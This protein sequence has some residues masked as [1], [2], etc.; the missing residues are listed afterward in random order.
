MKLDLKSTINTSTP[1]NKQKKMKKY[2]WYSAQYSSSKIR[3]INQVS[4]PFA[5]KK[6]K[7]IDLSE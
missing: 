4:P 1:K 2:I 5:P 7:K 6:K 3:D